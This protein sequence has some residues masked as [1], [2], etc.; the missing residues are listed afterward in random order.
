M[1]RDAR[2][3]LLSILAGAATGWAFCRWH[4]NSAAWGAAVTGALGGAAGGI[5]RAS[6]IEAV[7]YAGFA[8]LLL[9]GLHFGAAKPLV[10]TTVGQWVWALM[11]GAMAGGACGMLLGSLLPA[12]QRN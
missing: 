2:A 8:V 9:A 5:Q 3:I 7:I 12:D 6:R 11:A 10:A 4:A 1:S